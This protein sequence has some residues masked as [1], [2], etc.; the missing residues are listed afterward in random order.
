MRAATAAQ[1]AVGVRE[2]LTAEL[3]GLQYV[4]LIASAGKQYRTTL[5]DVP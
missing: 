3:A 4:T 1:L 5:R 2:Q